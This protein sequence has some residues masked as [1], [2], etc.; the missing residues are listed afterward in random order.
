M[1]IFLEK[2]CVGKPS[3]FYSQ[4]LLIPQGRITFQVVGRRPFIATSPCGI[5]GEW[6]VTETGFFFRVLQFSLVSIIPPM[7]YTTFIYYRRC[8]ILAD[9]QR[10]KLTITTTYLGITSPFSFATAFP[11]EY[12]EVTSSTFWRR[13][14][15]LNL[16]HPVYKMWTIQE[17]NTLELW[18]KLHFE[19]KETESI[20][21]V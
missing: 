18:S 19:E 11:S 1:Q 20:Y 9:W 10:P 15:F 14:Y 7:L 3:T 16:T 12:H 17:S 5:C 8:I 21:H 6:N 4:S 2:S 13:N